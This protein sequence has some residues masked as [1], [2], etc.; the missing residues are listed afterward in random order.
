MRLWDYNFGKMQGTK[1]MKINVYI[2]VG[3][4]RGWNP[5]MI[6]VNII[7]VLSSSFIVIFHVLY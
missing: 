6:R 4:H 5:S 3:Y 7:L 2:Y 1:L